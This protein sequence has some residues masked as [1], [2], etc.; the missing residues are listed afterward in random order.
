MALIWSNSSENTI[1]GIAEIQI[2]QN[3]QSV[4]S[5][6]IDSEA[7][8]LP[9]CNAGRW[10]DELPGVSESS[11]VLHYYPAY[12]YFC[13]PSPLSI[14]F[15]QL[16]SNFGQ[17][18]FSQDVNCCHDNDIY[19]ASSSMYISKLPQRIQNLPTIHN[20]HPK[21]RKPSHKLGFHWKLLHS[22]TINTNK[23]CFEA[24]EILDSLGKD[25]RFFDGNILGA[26]ILDT[27]GEPA[28]HVPR[29]PLHIML[30]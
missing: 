30:T 2:Q 16:R 1:V 4:E 19:P 6:G 27:L 7:H 22:V 12:F 5:C 28:P 17:I 26:R 14:S 3:A 8:L 23:P 20:F 15:S 11:L 13:L 9:Q 25:F 24:L 10:V 21:N 18:E 29:L